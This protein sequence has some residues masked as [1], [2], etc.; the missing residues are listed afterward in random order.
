MAS[1]MRRWNA[2][3]VVRSRLG[4]LLAVAAVAGLVTV[5]M[6]TSASGSGV[7]NSPGWRS[8]HANGYDTCRPQHVLARGS[9][10]QPMYGQICLTKTGSSSAQATIVFDNFSRSSAVAT[11]QVSMTAQT[12]GEADGTGIYECYGK[13]L[14]AYGYL[15]CDG[16]NLVSSKSDWFASGSFFVNGYGTSDTTDPYHM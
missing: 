14:P 8:S 7:A 4:R 6:A 9:D 5:G 13:T 3:S 2:G 16:K 1:R 15:F 12:L 11:A 10:G